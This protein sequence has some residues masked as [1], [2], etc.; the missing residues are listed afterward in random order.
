MFTL[1]HEYSL[2]QHHKLTLLKMSTVCSLLIYAI[3]EEIDRQGGWTHVFE[4]FVGLRWK[5]R[6]GMPIT[7]EVKGKK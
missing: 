1:I 3:Q 6:N 2:L 7:K 5:G 4:W